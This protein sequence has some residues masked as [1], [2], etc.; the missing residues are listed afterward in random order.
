MSL[1]ANW[2]SHLKDPEERKRFS[3]YIYS[4]RS[5]LD[6]LKTIVNEMQEELDQKE[7]NEEQYDSPSWAAL[8]A[9]RNGFRRALRRIHKLINLDQKD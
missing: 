8:Q 3:T 1:V 6:R 2:T 7:T 9:D 5:I 4:S